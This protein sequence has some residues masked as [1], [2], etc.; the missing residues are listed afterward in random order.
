MSWKRNPNLV[1]GLCVALG[2]ALSIIILLS[3]M[4]RCNHGIDFPPP[5]RESQRPPPSPKTVQDRETIVQSGKPALVMFYANSCGHSKAMLP[6]WQQAHQTLSQSGQ[7]EL[8]ALEQEKYGAEIQK[9]GISGF[10]TIRFYPEG[11]PSEK[12]IEYK[13]N[14]TTDSLIKFVKSGGQEV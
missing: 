8:I 5:S 12:F 2:I 3:V 9:H 14:R 10:P 11:F 4:P 1:V 6:S 7:F 13:G